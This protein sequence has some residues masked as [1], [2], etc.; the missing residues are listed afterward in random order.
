MDQGG[1]LWR[2]TQLREVAA[3]AGYDIEST[4]S[5]AGNENNKVEHTNDT[6][7]AMV[8]CLLYSAGISTK[9]LSMALVHA[10][11][12]KTRLFHKA[13]HETPYE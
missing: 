5:D 9:F 11:Y 10:V 3:T 4:C 12:L 13:I 1:G 7:G 6:F 2:S 8:R